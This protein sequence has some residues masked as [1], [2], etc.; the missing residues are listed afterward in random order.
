MQILMGCFAGCFASPGF[1]RFTHRVFYLLLLLTNLALPLG[2]HRIWGGVV[3]WWVFPV[4][5]AIAFY[6]LLQYLSGLYAWKFVG[7][8]YVFLYIGDMLLVCKVLPPAQ[9]GED[10]PKW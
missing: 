9:R 8:I 2:Q 10:Y 4:F 3:G 7:L 1:T 6:S 5:A